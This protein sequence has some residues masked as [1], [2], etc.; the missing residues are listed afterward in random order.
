M[1]RQNP[2]G[3][4][5]G[6]GG[7]G[8]SDFQKIFE[9]FNFFDLF[10]KVDQIDFP[11]FPKSLKQTCFGQIFCAAGKFWPRP[12]KSAPAPTDLKFIV[13]LIIMLHF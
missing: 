13:N 7:G 3:G 9:N 1:T 11:S 6:G 12:P 4:G 5:G 2:G 10:F 8:A